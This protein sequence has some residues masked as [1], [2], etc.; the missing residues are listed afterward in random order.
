M[1]VPALQLSLEV[2]RL[3]A[4]GM[5]SS[6]LDALLFLLSVF[7][8]QTDV[9]LSGSFQQYLDMYQ[10]HFD[11]SPSCHLCIDFFLHLNYE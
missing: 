4:L 8:P 7:K 5:R 11:F 9:P 10:A 1:L 2:S 6:K 3:T